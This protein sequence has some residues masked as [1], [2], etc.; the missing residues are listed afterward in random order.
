M[1][2]AAPGTNRVDAHAARINRA[3]D[4]IVNHLAE[5]L[6]L[7][8]V[9]RAAAF[10]PFHFHRLFRAATG[11]PLNQFVTRLRL[12][13]AL[14]LKLR[15]GRR[16]W[17]DIALA[18]GFGSASDFSRC[19]RQQHGTAPSRYDLAAHRARQREA[20]LA[21]LPEAQRHHVARRA[22][23]G[24]N[25]D[26]FRV[27][28]RRLPAMR[29]AYLR[30]T[31]SYQSGAVPAACDRLQEWAGRQG[32]AHRRWFGYMWDDPEVVPLAQCRYDVAVDIGEL[33]PD[34]AAARQV[35][36]HT[37]PPMEVAELT[38]R[39]DIALEMRALEWLF[40]TWLPASGRTPDAQPCFEA[41][42]GRPFAHGFEHF[43]LDLWLPVVRG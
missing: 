34:A 15:D 8:A 17:G 13:R 32:V 41:W 21:T 3:I 26:G 5:P 2:G 40:D 23:P 38:L 9:A 27:Q 16:S 4:H 25:P 43:E 29:V 37:F 10:S 36:L 35:G 14:S 12:E 30:V 22:V 24:E 33:R 39:G 19:F 11:Q 20:L 28:L 31:D 1:N 6:P 42:H 18:S 7:E